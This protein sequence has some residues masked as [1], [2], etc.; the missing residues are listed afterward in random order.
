MLPPLFSHLMAIVFSDIEGGH[1][2]PPALLEIPQVFLK[3]NRKHGPGDGRGIGIISV[4]KSSYD[5]L[6]YKELDE[7]KATW[8]SEAQV[9][10]CKWQHA[11]L[12]AA[13]FLEHLPSCT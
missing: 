7:W 8:L 1:E 5:T 4:W 10:G 3:K 6:C 11:S 12:T 9:G 13:D 2:W